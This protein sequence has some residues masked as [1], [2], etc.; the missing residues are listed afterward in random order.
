MNATTKVHEFLEKHSQLLHPDVRNVYN[1][2]VTGTANFDADA[3]HLSRRRAAQLRQRDE[4]SLSIVGNVADCLVSSLSGVIGISSSDQTAR[5]RE[6]LQSMSMMSLAEKVKSLTVS[7]HSDQTHSVSELELQTSIRLLISPFLALSA[8][9]AACLFG[10]GEDWPAVQH[11]SHL[12]E[13]VRA[14][15]IKPKDLPVDVL[16]R[17]RKVLNQYYQ[18]ARGEP[19][20]LPEGGTGLDKVRQR[21]S[22]A[23]EQPLYTLFLMLWSYLAYFSG[24]YQYGRRWYS[25]HEAPCPSPSRLHSGVGGQQRNRTERGLHAG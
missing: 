25:V 9:H 14:L 20:P 21:S 22:C 23:T 1:A 5:A 11:M 10:R 6:Q 8:A 3:I 18:A 15:P 4:L 2:A 16:E 12:Y 13:E 24:G 17:F 19:P 7:A